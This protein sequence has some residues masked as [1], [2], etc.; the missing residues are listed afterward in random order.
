MSGNNGSW[1][2][3]L[4]NFLKKCT[5]A[6]CRRTTRRMLGE[7]LTAGI[8]NSNSNNNSGNNAA[9]VPRERKRRS[10]MTAEEREAN[11][12]R[13][14]A[15][16]NFLTGKTEANRKA[17]A[18][19]EWFNAQR[20]HWESE[21]I[22]FKTP[23]EIAAEDDLIRRMMGM[24][25]NAER[26]AK[27]IEAE[28]KRKQERE[29]AERKRKQEREEAEARRQAE[30]NARRRNREAPPPLINADNAVLAAC[31]DTLIREGVFKRGEVYNTKIQIKKA[32]LRWALTNHPDKGG[33]TER[34]Q[35]VNDCISRL[36]AKAMN[37]GTRK[38]KK[39]ST[40]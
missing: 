28:R 3:T 27:E 25:T 12:A 33:N 4:K 20:K 21:G 1:R 14:A 34:F 6:S 13:R 40:K 26:I 37:G 29:E 8:L 32:F 38:N 16:R 30:E 2:K 39:R 7:N 36:I 5:S 17:A 23:A 15:I 19:K 31:R 22:R 24:N 10:S 11:N 18:D 35:I 9:Y